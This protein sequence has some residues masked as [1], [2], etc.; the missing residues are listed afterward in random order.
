MVFEADLARRGQG[1]TCWMRWSL[2][3]QETRTRRHGRHLFLSAAHFPLCSALA[4]SILSSSC[5]PLLLL[6]S[7]H[8]LTRSTRTPLPPLL[9]SGPIS[10]PPFVSRTSP[11]ASPAGRSTRTLEP[12][13]FFPTP[14]P[15]PV[16]TAAAAEAPHSLTGGSTTDLHDNAG[17]LP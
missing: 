11:A 13:F 5:Q 16:S 10:A 9:P 17:C 8:P 4:N 12:L 3:S 1:C 15:R 14:V 7:P 2:A 6:H